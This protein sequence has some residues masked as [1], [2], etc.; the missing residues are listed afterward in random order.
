MV[1]SILLYGC[2]TK[3]LTKFIDKKLAENCSRMLRFILNKF[4]KQ[5]STKQL[6][7]GHQPPTSKTTHCWRS[8]NELISDVFIWTPS[9]RRASVERRRIRPFLQQL[10]MDTGCS[11]RGPAGSDALCFRGCQLEVLFTVAPYQHDFLN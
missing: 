2:T 5:N 11:L 1:M 9:H 8:K 6:L 7:Y 4:W 3:T 10:C